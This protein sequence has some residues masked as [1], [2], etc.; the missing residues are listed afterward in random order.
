MAHPRRF[1]IPDSNLGQTFRAGAGNRAALFS[2]RRPRPVAGEDN[3]FLTVNRVRPDTERTLAP[4]TPRT[5]LPW[6]WRFEP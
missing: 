3:A 2:S 1:G 4:D 5:A 6:K